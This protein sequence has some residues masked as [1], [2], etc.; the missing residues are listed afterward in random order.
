MRA[1]Q[2]LDVA[3]LAV[4]AAALLPLLPLLLEAL[5]WFEQSAA[6]GDSVAQTNLGMLYRKGEVRRALSPTLYSLI[7]SRRAFRSSAALPS[8]TLSRP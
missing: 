1:R 8:F 4:V 3:L 5:E 7:P 2:L 6:M